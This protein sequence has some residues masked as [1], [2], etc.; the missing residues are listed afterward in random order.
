MPIPQEMISMMM[1]N[2]MLERITRQTSPPLIWKDWAGL[3]ASGPAIAGSANWEL[4]PPA[5]GR[6]IGAVCGNV[7]MNPL[8]NN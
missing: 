1:I 8:L 6:R 3:V 2:Q 7:V 5:R 4:G